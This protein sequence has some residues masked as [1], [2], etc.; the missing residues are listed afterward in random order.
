[1]K[2]FG[3]I[4]IAAVCLICGNSLYAQMTDEENKAFMEFMMPGKV[5]EMLAKA[6]GE[7]KESISF[8][9]KP[10]APPMQMNASCKNEMIMGGRYQLSATTGDM[11]GMPFEGHGVTGYDNVRKIFVSTWIDNMGTGIMYMEGQW[12][13]ASKSIEFVGKSTDPMAGKA[14]DMRQVLTFMD[15]NNHKLEMFMMHEGKEFKSM[16]IIFTR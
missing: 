7:W 15:D 12:N 16:E 14:I 4:F 8:W 2:L 1:M 6:N 13:E 10:G 11:M 3:K 5:H 9:M